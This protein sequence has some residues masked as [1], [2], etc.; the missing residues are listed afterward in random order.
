MNEW[1]IEWCT[2]L[3]DGQMGNQKKKKR[4]AGGEIDGLMNLTSLN[5]FS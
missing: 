2:D 4:K 1:M 3:M 5:L